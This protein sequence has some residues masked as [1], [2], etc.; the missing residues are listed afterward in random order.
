MKRTNLNG[1]IDLLAFAFL[2]LLT[3]TGLVE[4]YMLPPG[5]GKFQEL[6]SMDRHQWGEIHFWVATLLMAALT[7]HL[8]LHWKWILCVV[9]GREA[10]GSGRRFALGVVG[11]IGLVG[12][13]VAPFFSN[14]E[15][16]S[17]KEEGHGEIL[18]SMTL[19]EVSETSG[20]PV[21][22]IISELGLP[23]DV[24]LNENVGRLRRQHN[25]SMTEL[26]QALERI[27]ESGSGQH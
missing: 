26:R 17:E 4:R 5:S 12:L 15:Q 2:A 11:L 16:V 3:A 24:S 14:V 22:T 20:V 23:D 9:R 27:N 7:L 13:S 25:F 18:G 21:P 6:W 10:E 19:V 1:L 8:L